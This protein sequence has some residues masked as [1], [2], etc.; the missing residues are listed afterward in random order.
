LRPSFTT[1]FIQWEGVN[2]EK[3]TFY[4]MLS[5]VSLKLD[6]EKKRDLENFLAD[7]LLHEDIKITIQE[8]LGI[9][10]DYSI[11]NKDEIVK[12]MKRIPPLEQGPAWKM[13]KKAD[14]WGVDDS[15]EKIEVLYGVD[16]RLRH[17]NFCSGKV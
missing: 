9:M 4:C 3:S 10:V 7:L 16:W 6:R 17:R 14:D 1:A 5:S 12:R 13:L 2:A 11:E 8:A 15:S